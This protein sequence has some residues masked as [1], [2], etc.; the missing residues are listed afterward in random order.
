MLP[1]YEQYRP[2]TFDDMIGQDKALKKI[3]TLNRRGLAGRVYWITGGSGTGKTTLA[4]LIAKEVADDYAVIE[5]DAADL[6]MQ[7]VRNYEVICRSKP[8]GGGGHCFI[9]N[10]AHRLSGP[11]V[12]RL[13]STFERPEVQHN[14]TWLFTTTND[15]QQLFDD[16][17]DAS[18]FGSRCIDLPLSRRGLADCFAARAQE[19]ARS[20]GLDGQSL[21]A[22]V[23]LAKDCRNN[24]RMMLSRIESG[25]MLN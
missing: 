18:P 8:L 12:S 25:E 10:E 14:S 5:I 23:K 11:V 24:L 6:S 4:R 16:A 1:L 19:I 9:V 17:F 7:R 3:E 21:A 20:E 2:A 22:Y 15:G 13:L